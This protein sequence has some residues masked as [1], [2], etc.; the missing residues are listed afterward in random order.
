MPILYQHLKNHVT[1]LFQ[2]VKSGPGGRI[3]NL[4]V[5]HLALFLL[6]NTDP[7]VVIEDSPESAGALYNDLQFFRQLIPGSNRTISLFPPASSPELIGKRAS[8]LLASI[9][10]ENIGIITSPEACMTG[11]S[12]SRI[13][14]TVTTIRKGSSIE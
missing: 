6:F 13:M 8:V 11:F 7:F 9:T 4:S 2:Q 10:E 14:D 1:D 12:L 3:Y 5:P